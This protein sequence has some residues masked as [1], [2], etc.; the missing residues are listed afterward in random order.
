MSR[1]RR[2]DDVDVDSFDE[3]D[4]TDDDFTDDDAT[5]VY[6]D[7]NLA[8]NNHSRPSQF[9]RADITRT[10]GCDCKAGFWTTMRWT[11]Q[12]FIAII[13]FAIQS[14]YIVPWVLPS[15]SGQ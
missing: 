2:R 8:L 12:L 6:T 9:V 14:S 1:W 11:L 15:F 5:I 3:D 10:P 13:L 7:N 4:V